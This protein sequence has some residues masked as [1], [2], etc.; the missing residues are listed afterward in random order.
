MLTST[1]LRTL[2]ALVVVSALAL[3]APEPAVAGDC[4]ADYLVCLNEYGDWASSTILH[5]TECWGDYLHCVGRAI[6]ML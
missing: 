4:V 3:A 5:D 1:P 2:K 6:R